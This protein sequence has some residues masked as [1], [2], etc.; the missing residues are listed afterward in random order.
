MKNQFLEVSSSVISRFFCCLS[1]TC[2]FSLDKFCQPLGSQKYV[3]AEK[4]ACKF[5]DVREF[6]NDNLGRSQIEPPE[7]IEAY[8]QERK[9]LIWCLWRSPVML[10]ESFICVKTGRLLGPNYHDQE[11]KL[12]QSTIHFLVISMGSQIAEIN[13]EREQNGSR[14]FSLKQNLKHF[15]LLTLSQNGAGILMLILKLMS[16]R[17]VQNTLKF[18]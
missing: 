1:I 18:C 16:V 4:E 2:I 9:Y 10:N 6:S 14:S 15:Q 17:L 12:F 5:K 7:T 11:E 3:Y 8:F 13:R